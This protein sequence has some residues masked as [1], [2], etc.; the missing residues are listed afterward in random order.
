MKGKWVV[1]PNGSFKLR[2]GENFAVC[3]QTGKGEKEK[4][5]RDV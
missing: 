5:Q 1:G 4:A 3:L 2:R